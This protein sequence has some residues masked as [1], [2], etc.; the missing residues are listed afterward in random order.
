MMEYAYKTLNIYDD[1]NYTHYGD[2]HP[3]MPGMAYF[4]KHAQPSGDSQVGQV[5]ASVLL[6]LNSVYV[7]TLGDGEFLENARHDSSDR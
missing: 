6:S 4:D 3:K 5:L 1:K 2:N 7:R